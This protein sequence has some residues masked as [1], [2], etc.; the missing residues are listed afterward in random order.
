MCKDEVEHGEE[1]VMKLKSHFSSFYSDISNFFAKENSNCEI[2][3]TQFKHFV[4]SV[5]WGS[6]DSEV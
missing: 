6:K 2:I 4:T 1:G 3:A 5:R